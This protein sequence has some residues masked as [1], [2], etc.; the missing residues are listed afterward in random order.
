MPVINLLNQTA[1]SKSTDE[2]SANLINMYLTDDKDQ[3][4]YSTA[5]YPTP[6]ATLF[7]AGNSVIRALFTEH[8][9]TY[10]IDG[11]TFFSVSSTGV[12]T[13][14]GTLLTSTGWAKIQGIANQLLI[15]D[16]SNIY[17]YKILLNTF[18]H[19]VATTYVSGVV[20]TA[21]GSGYTTVPTVVF[22]D[23]TGTGAAGTAVIAGG[24]VA[25]VILT[26]VGSGYTAPTVSFSGGGGTGAAA[27][28]QTTTTSPPTAIQ[29][30]ACQ[31][32]FGLVLNQNSQAWNSSSVSDLT[33]W[34]ALSFAST[35][36][37][38][39]YNVG[40]TSVHRE[41]YILGTTTSEV[42]DNLGTANFSFGRNQTAFIEYGCSARSSIAKGDN[43]FFF[44]AKSPAGG[45]VIMRMNGYTP[46]KV[47]NRAIDYQ[48]STYSTVSDAVGMIYQQEG[49][50]FYVITF[51][52]AGVTWVY[53]LTTQLWHQRQSLIS[54][55]QVQWLA[56]S[57]TFG[58]NKCLVGDTNTGNMYQLDMT[59][60][61]ENG[62]AIT[63]TLVTHPFYE[64]GVWIYLDK[65]Q[66]D[67][68]TTP[69]TALSNWNLSISRN[70]GY[71]FGTAKPA[72][73]QL[74]VNGMYRVY[75]TRLGISRSYVFKIST[76]ANMKTI[77]LGAWLNARPGA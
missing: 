27:T 54:G 31:D 74:D 10:G 35:T 61:T 56:G 28:V 1:T 47:S 14:L 13:T 19:V 11:S 51:P 7:S 48:I 65:L 50:E 20:M 57:Y 67:F 25:S 42:W 29:D 22:T 9:I 16:S 38:Q 64:V 66:V 63:R 75:W 73:P 41:I 77:I 69:G 70:G 59:N 76:S 43:T 46:V 49:H 21:A 5:A 33:T 12:R 3:G 15:A 34:P 26:A 72:V 4:K 62:A 24:Q 36:G 52:T 45:S 18:S 60:N 32:E 30:I 68:D 23:A 40:I 71:T 2:N 39:N 53:D 58:Y 44:L 55:N 8:G 37:D 17:C 6:G